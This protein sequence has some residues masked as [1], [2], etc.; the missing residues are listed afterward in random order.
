[1]KHCVYDT[2]MGSPLCRQYYEVGLLLFAALRSTYLRGTGF[3]NPQSPRLVA[4]LGHRRLHVAS[5][6]LERVAPTPVQ[7]HTASAATDTQL[8]TTPTTS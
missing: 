6:T 3:Y 7:P 4:H 2:E 5:L 1:M 8:P